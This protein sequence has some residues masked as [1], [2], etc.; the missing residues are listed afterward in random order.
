MSPQQ[1]TEEEKK[2]ARA[3]VERAQEKLV[4]AIKEAADYLQ[5]SAQALVINALQLHVTY[6]DKRIVAL[7]RAVDTAA[8]LTKE[9]QDEPR[10][11]EELSLIHI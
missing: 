2:K 4:D 7:E 1:P 10:V 3:V 5:H 9:E 8:R 6:I 11:I